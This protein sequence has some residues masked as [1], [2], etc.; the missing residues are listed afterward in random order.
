MINVRRSDF[1]LN[2][3]IIINIFNVLIFDRKNVV[4]RGLRSDFVVVVVVVVVLLDWQEHLYESCIKLVF[5]KSGR[6]QTYTKRSNEREVVKE[7]Y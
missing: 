7:K 4:R 6:F 1:C 5:V 3:Q 2:Y